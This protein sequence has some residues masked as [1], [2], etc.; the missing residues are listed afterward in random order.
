LD[1]FDFV[2]IGAGSAGEA[3][4]NKALERGASAAIVERDLFGGSCP[5]WACMPSK[6]LL[7]AATGHVCGDR[8]PWSRAAGFRDYM[9]NREDRAYPDDGGHEQALRDAGAETLRGTARIAGPGR[10][11]VTL[12]EGGQRALRGRHIVVATGSRTKF[13]P[14]DGLDDIEPWSNREGTS[15][16]ELPRSLLILGGGPTGVELGQVFA[17]FG[18]PVTLVESNERIL[19]RDHPRNSAAVR[20]GLERDGV[21]VRTGTRAQRVVPGGGADGAHRVELG[22]GASVEG[23]EILLAIGRDYD[24][25]DVGLES[26]GIDLADLKPDGRLRLGDGLWLVGDPAGPELHTHISHYQGEMAVRMALG[27]EVRPDY[28]AIPRCTY[29]DPEAAFVGLSLEDAQ[30]AGHDAVEFVEDLAKSA[31]GYVAEAGGHVTVVVDRRDRRLLG[32]A[33]AGPGATEAIHEAVL[34]V[35][36]RV[37][38]AVLADTIHAFPTTARVL[39]TAFGRAAQALG[40]DG[41]GA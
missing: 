3:A 35:K 27:E 25:G 20:E 12:K 26:V 36:T 16:T 40:G 15:A 22:D 31:K 23:H 10:V 7:H 21:T 38:V 33:I 28:S 11:D 1:R 4:A 39:G 13:P 14:M 19:A 18:V 8:W 6:A 24:L 2:I 30:A 34:A 37:P 17:R 32:A 9:I 29:T 41:S 5:F